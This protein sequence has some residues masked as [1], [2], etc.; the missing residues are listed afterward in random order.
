M[1]KEKHG[2]MY[3]KHGH[4]HKGMKMWYIKFLSEEDKKKLALKKIEMKISQK[5]Q[6]IE[7]LEMMHEMIKAKM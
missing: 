7:M 2:Y 1:H 6:S 4:M 5:K 3:G